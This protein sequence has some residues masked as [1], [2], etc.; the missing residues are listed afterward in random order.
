MLVSLN[1]D[2]EEEEQQ[3]DRILDKFQS[4]FWLEEHNWFVQCDWN[5]NKEYASLHTLPYAFDSFRFYLPVQSKSISPSDIDL[6][7]YSCVHNL[8]YHRHLIF[9]F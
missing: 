6:P 5:L 3:I 1:N 9:S 7:S 4:Q 8:M 2:I